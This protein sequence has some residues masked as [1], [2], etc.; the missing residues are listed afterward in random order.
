[1]SF[2]FA[3]TFYVDADRVQKAAE[4]GLS[5][6]EL[7]FRGKP[8]A[9][10]NKSGIENPG[11]RVFI[12]P[13]KEG[14]P[15]INELAVIRPQEPTE[16]GAR[17]LV[18]TET[19]RREYDEIKTSVDAT[20]PTVFKFADPIQVN[21]NQLW[22][23]VVKFDGDEDFILWTAKSG[24]VQI[25][26]FQRYTGAGDFQGKLFG[27][28]SPTATDHNPGAAGFG[29]GDFA[30]DPAVVDESAVLQVDQTDIETQVAAA[31]EYLQNAWKP[32]A[33]EDLMF[34]VYAAAYADNGYPVSA[35]TAYPVSEVEP[36]LIPPT[37][38]SNNLIRIVSP[39]K[40]FEF[41]KFDRLTSNTNNL[42]FGDWFWQDSP[43]YP[44]GT[45]TPLTITIS[46]GSVNVVGNSAYLYANGTTFN[47]ANGWNEVY[48]L[49]ADNEYIVIDSGTDIYMRKIVSILSN[50]VLTV[51][52]P[53]PETNTVAKFYKSAV[54]RLINKTRSYAYGLIEEIGRLVDSNPNSSVRFVNNCIESITVTA[55]GQ[56][57][58][59]DD[60]VV[61][62]GYEDVAGKVSGGYSAYANVK[63]NA[64]GNVTALHMSNVGCG[65]VLDAWLQGSNVV[66]T[67]S[68]GQPV[69][70]GTANGLTMSYNIGAT[71]KSVYSA[72]NQFFSNCQ[73]VNMPVSQIKPEITVNN[74]VGTG[75]VTKFGTSYYRV[76]DGSIANSE[77][78]YATDDP[79]LTEQV[80]KIFKEH[81]INDITDAVVPSRSNEFVTHYSNGA[82]VNAAPYSFDTKLSNSVFFVFEVSSNN[83]YTIP[84]FQPEVTQ[85][86][87]TKYVINNDYTNEHTNYGN[88]YAKHVVTK[89]NFQEDRLAEDIVVYLTCYRP[90]GT[91]F[92]VYARIHNSADPEAFDDKDWTLLDQT[93]GIGVY[94]SQVD[95]TDYIELTYGFRYWPNSS[96]T[97]TNTVVA[98]LDSANVDT[99]GP[100]TFDSAIV[101]D[102]IV[103]VYQP[104]FPNNYVVDVVESVTNTSQIILRN[105]VANDNVVGEGLKIEKIGFPQQGFKYVSNSN[106]I[107]YYNSD[108]SLFTRYDTFQIKVIL[109]SDDGSGKKIPKIDD[110]RS[111]GV[112]A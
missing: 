59:N 90:V 34:G 10:N 54:G 42:K 49:S 24:D 99:S 43:A 105:P 11:A 4:V 107:R 29:Y 14:I 21:T 64:S 86:H 39:S 69:P 52:E 65:F 12:A 44:G 83:D 26:N 93:D 62:S 89:V 45:T 80:V 55:N 8:K 106:V 41:F 2:S 5:A 79:A 102:D 13:T 103:R 97:Q 37:V 33:D 66:V 36:A 25:D 57:Y 47:N 17:F 101:V 63:T 94:S 110:I 30:I 70:D 112:T 95:D 100:D 77:V 53:F 61:I 1:V 3:Q 56:G 38:L 16:H 85:S 109:L 87:L 82:L 91:D 96:F 50:T 98:V 68:S 73:F 7:Y 18:K 22:A 32:Y 23:L 19:A 58:S 15:V 74:P 67:N 48:Q 35:N 81:K 31:Q 60:Y 111:V 78:I 20:V 6:V 71:L 92:K 84:F 76:T 108:K 104:L 27:F 88:A 46:N 9:T 28:V 75:F 51:D 72:A 40:S